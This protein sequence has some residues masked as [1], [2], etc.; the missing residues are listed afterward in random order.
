MSASATQHA[1]AEAQQLRAE[2]VRQGLEQA[3]RV[4]LPHTVAELVEA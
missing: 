4:R 2:R 1:A 3:R